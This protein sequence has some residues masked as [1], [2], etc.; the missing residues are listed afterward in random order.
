MLFIEKPSDGIARS[1]A[2][3]IM[4][5]PALTGRSYREPQD[6]VGTGVG[7]CPEGMV[8][9]ENVERGSMMDVRSAAFAR[10]IVVSTKNRIHKARKRQPCLYGK[11]LS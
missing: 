5:M 4:E 6:V 11:R 2:R 9:V 10:D 8:G 3:I 1:D 7:P